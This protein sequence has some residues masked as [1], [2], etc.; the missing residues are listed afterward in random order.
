MDVTKDILVHLVMLANDPLVVGVGHGY[1]K[2]N[3]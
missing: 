1:R 3:T 2:V